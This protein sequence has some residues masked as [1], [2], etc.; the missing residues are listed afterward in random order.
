MRAIP[1]GGWRARD[2][3]AP[4]PHPHPLSLLPRPQAERYDEMTAE[5]R[6]ARGGMP[7]ARAGAT[8]LFRYGPARFF[9][10][11]SHA[12]KKTLTL[13][14]PPSLPTPQMTKV[15][16][17]A[18]DQELSVEERN[19]LSVAFKNV[20]GAR[21]ASWR[22][23]SSIEQKEDAKGNE[24]HVARI[25]AYRDVVSGRR[26]GGEGA[27]C[28]GFWEER[29]SR[30][31]ARMGGGDA[32]AR[33]ARLPPAFSPP[34]TRWRKALCIRGSRLRAWGGRRQGGVRFEVE[35]GGTKKQTGPQKPLAPRTRVF[36]CFDATARAAPPGATQNAP[37]FLTL[38]PSV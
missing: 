23:V 24:A 18:S 32:D 30:A 27:R 22:I 28:D 14:S 25:K 29:G 5:V 7:R 35:D 12:R 15:A 37:S 31:R 4:R 19:L 38:Q 26:G 9:V 34:T 16:K 8:V 20:I 10:F 6:R 11:P 21:R 33:R 1:A 2:T 13:P 36:L 17:M 3:R